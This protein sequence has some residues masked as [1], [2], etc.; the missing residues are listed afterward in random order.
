MGWFKIEEVHSGRLKAFWCDLDNLLERTGSSS[1][2]CPQNSQNLMLRPR[3]EK[4][5]CF[6][7]KRQRQDEKR[8]QLVNQT[9]Q[10]GGPRYAEKNQ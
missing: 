7:T 9:L 10:E 4:C 1:D 6:K 8:T 3:P 2:L 5:K